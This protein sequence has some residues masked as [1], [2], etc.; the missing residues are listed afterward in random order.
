MTHDVWETS[1]L[2]S[3]RAELLRWAVEELRTLITANGNPWAE[4]KT[5]KAR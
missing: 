2:A 3:M 5:T 1:F 4:G